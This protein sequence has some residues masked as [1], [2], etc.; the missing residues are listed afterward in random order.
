[1]L[2]HNLRTVPRY[3]QGYYKITAQCQRVKPSRTSH[4]T[5]FRQSASRVAATEPQPKKPRLARPPAFGPKSELIGMVKEAG[6]SL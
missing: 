6:F 1:M 3:L 5:R 2:K 4:F